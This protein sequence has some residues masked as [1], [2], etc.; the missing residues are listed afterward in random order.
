[1]PHGCI[2]LLQNIGDIKHGRK[3]KIPVFNLET[4]SR[5]CF[6][7]LEISEDCGVVC[8]IFI[9]VLLKIAFFFLMII[10]IEI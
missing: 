6:K 2:C 1:M 9:S 3:T 7:E 4:G 8:Y 10:F 5:S